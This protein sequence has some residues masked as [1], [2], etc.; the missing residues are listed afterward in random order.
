MD[1]VDDRLPEMTQGL[2]VVVGDRARFYPL[3]A[4]DADTEHGIDDGWD[5]QTLH[6]G[7]N[8]IDRV[9]FATWANGSR[10]FQLFTRWYGFV[11]TF[12]TCD[13]YVRGEREQ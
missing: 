13:A 5:G 3:T 9:P 12:P 10:P 6:V 1:E 2:G 8:P 4:L 11:L 7:R